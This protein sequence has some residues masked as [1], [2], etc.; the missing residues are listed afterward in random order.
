[1][2]GTTPLEYSPFNYTF[3][4]TT[5]WF[6]GD[7]A[8][9][10]QQQAQQLLA[11]HAASFGVSNLISSLTTGGST[12]A[13]SSSA[14]RAMNF[15]SVAASGISSSLSTTT[16]QMTQAT[17]GG[18]INGSIGGGI[19]AIGKPLMGDQHLVHQHHQIP[20]QQQQ[21]QDMSNI[22]GSTEHNKADASKAPG[23]RGGNNSMGSP[24]LRMPP[25]QQHLSNTN[26]NPHEQAGR[27]NLDMSQQQQHPNNVMNFNNNAR[28]SAG[29]PS[30]GGN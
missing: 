13:L 6:P 20:I 12:S 2:S 4:K 22:V 9:R 17:G 24:I 5:G 18:I 3:S 11:S 1:M 15:A 8:V 30:V 10:E 26:N 14:A 16:A 29:P 21:G 23:Y 28:P 19:S 27:F 25:N 7:L